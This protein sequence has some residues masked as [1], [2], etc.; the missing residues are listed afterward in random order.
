LAD[1]GKR[2][3]LVST[4]PASNLDDVL[5]TR[6]TNDPTA[7]P[8]CNNLFAVNIDPEEAARCYR[9]RVIGPFRGVLPD[10]SLASIE[11]QLSG[12]CTM[13]I[14]AFDEFVR[15]LGDKELA[16]RHD[17][18]VFDTAPPDTLF[19]CCNCRR[20]GP[21]FSTKTPPASPVS[22]LFQASRSRKPCTGAVA[23]LADGGTNYPL[24]CRPPGP[25]EPG[26]SGP[27]QRRT[28]QTRN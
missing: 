19:A 20:P 26:R 18:I 17:H 7:I 12:A 23:A 1:R 2:V 5:G 27:H 16:A 22:A 21:I 4:D 9:E 10:E 8:E 3:L 14:A 15:L 6:V 11:E 25:G 13:E 24:S 28:G